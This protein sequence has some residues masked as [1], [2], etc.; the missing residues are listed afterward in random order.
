MTY[1]DDNL[2]DDE[3]AAR[4]ADY[5]E[6]LAHGRTPP[7]GD[8]VHDDA[9]RRRLAEAADCLVL[10]EAAWPRDAGAA[11]DKAATTPLA[12]AWPGDAG[13]ARDK[14][15]DAPFAFSLPTHLGRFRLKREL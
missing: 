6:A 2:C 4:L 11:R 9:L 7:P 12:A 3:F 10:L 14:A 13:A 8:T 15:A 5:D 1:P